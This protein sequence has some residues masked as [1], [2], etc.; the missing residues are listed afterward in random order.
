MYSRRSIWWCKIPI[1]QHEETFAVEMKKQQFH[2][3][4]EQWN[5]NHGHGL[6]VAIQVHSITHNGKCD[7]TFVGSVGFKIK[8]IKWSISFYHEDNK[9]QHWY[10]ISMKQCCFC[11]IKTSRQVSKHKCT[12]DNF[13]AGKRHRCGR[14]HFTHVK[15]VRGLGSKNEP[16]YAECMV[17]PNSSWNC[18]WSQR[19]LADTHIDVQINAR[20]EADIPSDCKV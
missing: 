4:L 2:M 13:A 16:N 8:M 1:R 7:D 5:C 17:M 18:V 9:K 12:V 10:H 3:E 15:G 6:V 20:M 19:P 14:Q 11:E